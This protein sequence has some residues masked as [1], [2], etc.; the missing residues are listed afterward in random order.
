MEKLTSPLFP[1][2]CAGVISVMQKESTSH[3]TLELSDCPSEVYANHIWEILLTQPTS[4][5]L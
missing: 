2:C 5:E 3:L 4:N 1:Q